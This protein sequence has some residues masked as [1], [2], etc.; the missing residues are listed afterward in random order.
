M[1]AFDTPAQSAVPPAMVGH[2]SDRT[3]QPLQFLN[4]EF[5]CKVSA[6][7]TEGALCIYDTWRTEP[8][9]PPMHVHHAQD[10]WFFVLEG[11]FIVKVADRVHRLHAGDSIL[12]RRGLPHAFRC[13][14]DTG[15]LVIVFQ[16]AGSMEAFFAE[17]S[18]LGPLTPPAFAELSARHQMTIVGP[19]LSSEDAASAE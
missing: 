8:G 14:S 18:K 17:G 9:G 11:A 7:D 12:G 6:E 1:T 5:Y 13:M 10:E 19:P 4:G 15:R 16:P 3:G 2:R